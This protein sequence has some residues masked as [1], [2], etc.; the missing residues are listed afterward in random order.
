MVLYP[1]EC[2]K[3]LKSGTCIASKR[4]CIAKYQIKCNK[5]KDKVKCVTGYTRWAMIHVFN[6]RSIGSHVAHVQLEVLPGILKR[7]FFYTKKYF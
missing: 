3:I 1:V 6:T 4:F 2:N 5:V 7:C